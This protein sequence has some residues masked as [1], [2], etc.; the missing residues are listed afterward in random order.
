MAKSFLLRD[1]DGHVSGYLQIQQHTV[2]CRLTESTEELR[3]ELILQCN[4]KQAE[5][6]ALKSGNAEQCFSFSSSKG[7]EISGAVVVQEGRVHLYTDE[8]AVR[9]HDQCLERKKDSERQSESAVRSERTDDRLQPS[10]KRS[11]HWQE[12]VWPQKRWPPPICIPD[13]VY[14]QGQ[15]LDCAERIPAENQ[16]GR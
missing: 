3:D 5:C 9:I 14:H 15:W 4:D 11:S 8:K 1:R 6:F 16:P 2:R 13:A 12:Y 7:Q 10:L